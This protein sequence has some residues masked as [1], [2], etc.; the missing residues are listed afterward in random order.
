MQKWFPLFSVLLLQVLVACSSVERASPQPTIAIIEETSTP[1]QTAA[2]PVELATQPP[3]PKSAG[4]IGLGLFCTLLGAKLDS[5][6][7]NVISA[8]K[9]LLFIY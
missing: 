6:G 2:S 4:L 3:N 7:Y 8:K 9:N 1:V 5:K